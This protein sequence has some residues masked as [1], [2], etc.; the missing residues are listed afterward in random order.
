MP[1]CEEDRD[2]HTRSHKAAAGEGMKAILSIRI[3]GIHSCQQE[4]SKT[5]SLQLKDNCY[6]WNKTELQN[7]GMSF[8]SVGSTV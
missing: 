3:I 1:N 8:T 5:L 2:L 7:K 4:N 6:I